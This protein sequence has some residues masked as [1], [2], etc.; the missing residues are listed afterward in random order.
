MEMAVDL[1]VIPRSI[2]SCLDKWSA[3]KGIQAYI[4]DGGPWTRVEDA[5][6][7]EGETYDQHDG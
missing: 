6:A 3:T 1:M 2:S 7:Q 4:R 5:M